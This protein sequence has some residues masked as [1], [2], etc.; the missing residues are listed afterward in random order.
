MSRQ[1][2]RPSYSHFNANPWAAYAAAAWAFVFA[3][4]SFYWALGGTVGIE[5]LALTIQEEA[6][7]R[8]TAFLAMVWVTGGLKVLGGLLAL[9]LARPWG[10][11]IPRR[12]LLIVAWGAG[13]LLVLYEGASW[14]EAALMEAGVIDVP[15][16]LGAD[17]VRWN[18]LLWRPWWVLGGT[19]FV[20]AARDFG[21]RTHL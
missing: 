12:L 20:L 11:A 1:Q 16:S 10:R 6:R 2:A 7:Q 5:T 9:A 21:R 15:A 13:V 3:A 19:L 18:M 4:N 14:V 17:A 8:D